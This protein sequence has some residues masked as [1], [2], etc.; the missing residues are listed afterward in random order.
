[1]FHP[2]LCKRNLYT[3]APILI[4]FSLLTENDC[5]SGQK[6]FS[7]GQTLTLSRE[8]ATLNRQLF[9][10]IASQAKLLR[11]KRRQAELFN[12]GGVCQRQ[13]LYKEE[14]ARASPERVQRIATQKEG[15]C[16]GYQ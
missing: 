1:V 5:R 9:A 7:I 3:G 15:S 13:E 12:E 8:T 4:L 2:S 6:Q 14:G 11:L 16:L 10:D